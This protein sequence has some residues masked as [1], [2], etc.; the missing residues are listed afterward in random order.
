MRPI[1]HTDEPEGEESDERF[2]LTSRRRYDERGRDEDV[3]DDDE[4]WLAVQ[5]F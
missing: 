3:P 2:R 4:L 1:P 5:E